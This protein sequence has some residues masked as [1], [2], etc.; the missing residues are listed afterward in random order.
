MCESSKSAK[1]E[2]FDLAVISNVT[3]IHSFGFVGILAFSAI[4]LVNTIFAAAETRK[5]WDTFTSQNFLTYI[6]LITQP[7]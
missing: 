1:T 6:F 4:F 2:C 7:L 5:N 3:R